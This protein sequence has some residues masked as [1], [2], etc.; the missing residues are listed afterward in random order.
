[1]KPILISPVL[2]DE[3]EKK[4]LNE[5][6]EALVTEGIDC[7]VLNDNDIR[8]HIVIIETQHEQHHDILNQL[9]PGQTKILFS[10]EFY[11]DKNIV[12]IVKPTSV[13]SLKKLIYTI[14][15]KIRHLN[16]DDNKTTNLPQYT[17]KESSIFHVLLNAKV[18]KKLLSLSSDNHPNLYVDGI[19]NT[20]VSSAQHS[21]M[22]DILNKSLDGFKID[23]ISNDELAAFSVG[24]NVSSLDSKLW[25]SAVT[26]SNGELLDGHC[27]DKAFTLKEWPH[28]LRNGFKTDYVKIA[29]IL[30][31]QS[32]SI[33]DLEKSTNISRTD[34]IN[35]YNAAFAVGLIVV[36]IEVD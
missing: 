21:E 5:V 24:L 22:E 1:M 20:I 34:I 11:S 7:A 4:I 30:A 2:L 23:S 36:F 33:N 16:V 14:S 26:W 31:R 12:S 15:L 3:T 27:D 35:F 10:S 28:F 13:F 18:D 9:R 29:A 8:G 32:C 19:S 17:S 25:V 6:A